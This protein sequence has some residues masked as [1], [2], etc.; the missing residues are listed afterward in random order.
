M[1]NVTP[2]SLFALLIACGETAPVAPTLPDAGVVAAM[3][4]SI[5]VDAGAAPDA[6]VLD[7][8]QAPN[9]AAFVA[10]VEQA[11]ADLETFDVPA[12]GLAVVEHG[13]PTQSTAVGV[14]V[15]GGTESVDGETLFAAGSISKAFVAAAAMDVAGEGR[16]DLEAPIGQY[17]PGF[18][19][20]APSDPMQVN[21]RSLLG[22]TSGYP[23]WI[24]WSQADGNLDPRDPEALG[25][26]F[27][28]HDDVVLWVEPHQIW[29]Y[30]NVGYSLAALV[31]ERADGQWWHQSIQTRIFDRLAMTTA[32][33]QPQTTS[34]VQFAHGRTTFDGRPFDIGPRDWGYSSIGSPNGGLWAS[35]ADLAKYA[36]FLIDPD[37]T[38][39]PMQVGSAESGGTYGLGT[40][41]F[42]Y[43]GLRVV[44]HSGGIPGF[45]AIVVAVPE[46]EFGVVVMASQ[47]RYNIMRLVERAL[48]EFLEPAGTTAPPADPP[49]ETAIVGT[50]VDAGGYLGTL[51]I[52]DSGSGLILSFDD[53]S[54]ERPLQHF[55]GRTFFVRNAPTLPGVGQAVPTIVFDLW[56]GD[57]GNVAHVASRLGVA[58]R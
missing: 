13:A 18:G 8:G 36:A 24:P 58:S 22:H 46:R 43:R 50:Y 23:T 54:E 32:T 47:D 40:M 34:N 38:F 29:N 56:T 41:I 57:D 42:D 49:A 14:R 33:F 25:Q 27:E 11:T 45:A 35:P 26:Y 2:L 15:S 19:L 16:L 37:E 28:S 20:G 51:T 55:E 31:L 3:D 6:A 21:L 9:E 30:S 7:A 5:V 4:A 1:K 52:R 53:L 17:F 39:S 44:G 10:L 12:I 48:D